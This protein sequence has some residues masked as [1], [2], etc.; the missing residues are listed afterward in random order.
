MVSRKTLG[1][2]VVTL[3]ETSATSK[4]AGGGSYYAIFGTLQVVVDWLTENRIAT[5]N[6][7][8]MTFTSNA[9]LCVIY[10]K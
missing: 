1:G 2:Q 5:N 3:T 6:I 10:R 4:P 9:E 8:G 7:A